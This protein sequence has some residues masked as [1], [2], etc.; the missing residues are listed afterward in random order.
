MQPNNTYNQAKDSFNSAKDT[1]KD[2][3]KDT[4]SKASSALTE[5]VT[6]ARQAGEK[7][8]TANDLQDI[9][10]SLRDG[11]MNA[12]D[13][14][15]DLIK[16]YPFTTVLGAAAVGAVVGTLFSRIRH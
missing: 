16:K 15:E 12:A 5:T 10:A 2:S 9:I 14:S 11:A 1:V 6:S 7:A 4:A 8:L 3:V 13:K